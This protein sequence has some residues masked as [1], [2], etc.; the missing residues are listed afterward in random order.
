MYKIEFTNKMKRDVKRMVK[1]GKNMTKL[2][3]ALHLLSTGATLP[4]TYRDHQLHG[5]LKEYRECHIEG[6]WLLIYQII[7]DIL[8]LSAAGTG[9]HADLFNM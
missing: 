7:E 5:K 6:D 2:A 9:T 4:P 3:A 1:R 8:I